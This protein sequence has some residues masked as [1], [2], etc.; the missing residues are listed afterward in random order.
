MSS[1]RKKQQDKEKAAAKQTLELLARHERRNQRH[2][3]MQVAA[4]EEDYEVDEPVYL[5]DLDQKGSDSGLNDPVKG[6]SLT[7]ECE[8]AAV[9]TGSILSCEDQPSMPHTKLDSRNEQKEAVQI[10]S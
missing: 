5:V 9:V 8:K 4:A 6:Q 1:Q 7:G 3:A 10:S 2:G